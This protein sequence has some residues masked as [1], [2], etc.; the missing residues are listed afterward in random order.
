VPQRLWYGAN[1]LCDDVMS[2]AKLCVRNFSH[3]AIPVN[4]ANEIRELF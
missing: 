2:G 3:A 4:Y 1:N